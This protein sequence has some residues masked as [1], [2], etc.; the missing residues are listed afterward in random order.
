[1]F[2]ETIVMA[3]KIVALLIFFPI[4]LGAVVYAYRGANRELME[5][6]GRIPFQDEGA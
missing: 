2:D 6:H 3:S 5:R 1:M 4:Y